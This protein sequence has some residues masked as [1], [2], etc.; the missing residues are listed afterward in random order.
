MEARST[1]AQSQ[2]WHDTTAAV[3]FRLPFFSFFCWFSFVL[4]WE[5]EN[6]ET[7]YEQEV[8]DI[9]LGQQPIAAGVAAATTQYVFW[10]FP[11]AGVRGSVR[12]SCLRQDNEGRRMRDVGSFLP[13]WKREE[14]GAGEQPSPRQQGQ[15][16]E[17]NRVALATVFGGLVGLSCLA[18]GQSNGQRERTAT[19]PQLAM[20]ENTSLQR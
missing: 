11:V 2:L 15:L 10:G 16:V 18:S 1:S 17:S 9:T 14:G 8:L 13:P 6:C 4:S 19:L 7:A 5:V 3:G 20:N 12:S